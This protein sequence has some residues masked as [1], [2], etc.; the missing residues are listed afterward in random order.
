MIR[1]SVLVGLL[2][3]QRLQGAATV[4]NW[5]QLGIILYFILLPAGYCGVGV[6]FLLRARFLLEISLGPRASGG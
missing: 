4:G 2:V 6:G 1:D 5:C 3:A